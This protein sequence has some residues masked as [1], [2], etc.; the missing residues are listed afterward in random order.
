MKAFR[1]VQDI[2]YGKR[3]HWVKDEEVQFYSAFTQGK[4]CWCHFNPLSAQHL[5]QYLL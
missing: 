2:E 5:L 3:Y 4:L 1:N